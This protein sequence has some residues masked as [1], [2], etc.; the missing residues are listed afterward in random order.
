ML[1]ENPE[2]VGPIV[3]EIPEVEA[4]ADVVDAEAEEVVIGFDGETV[5]AEDEPTPLIKQ[6]GPRSKPSQAGAR[7]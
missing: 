3:D 2:D 5:E 7:T 1:D 4:P 6:L